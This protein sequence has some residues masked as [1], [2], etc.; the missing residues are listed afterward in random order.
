MPVNVGSVSDAGLSV[1][2]AL[3]LWLNI[4]VWHAACVDEGSGGVRVCHM[5]QEHSRGIMAEIQVYATVDQVR[6]P[7]LAGAAWDQQSTPVQGE[8]ARV[9]P[10]LGNDSVT[11]YN[12]C[13]GC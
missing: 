12:R 3:D 13:G 10:R 9:K 8:Y 11:R 4:A 7:H 1:L 2:P 6:P 5:Q